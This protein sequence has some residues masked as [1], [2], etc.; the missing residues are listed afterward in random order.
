M[1]AFRLQHINKVK[2]KVSNRS[3]LHI[4]ANRI[5]YKKNSCS[6]INIS[7]RQ[8]ITNWEVNLGRKYKSLQDAVMKVRNNIKGK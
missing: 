7:W 4:K 5:P 1:N 3:L 6:E 2:N 8:K